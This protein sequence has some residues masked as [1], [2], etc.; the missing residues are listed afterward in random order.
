MYEAEDMIEGATPGDPVVRLLGMAFM[1]PV[2]GYVLVTPGHPASKGAGKVLRALCTVLVSAAILVV[3]T[4][5][6][7]HVSHT[8]INAQYSAFNS[9]KVEGELGIRI[10]L[11][12]ATVQLYGSVPELPL[13]KV[14]YNEKFTFSYAEDMKRHYH[15]VLERGLPYPVLTAAEYL[16][17]DNDG[18]RWGRFYRQ[19]GYYS[20]FCLWSAFAL[21]LLSNILWPVDVRYSSIC[22][23]I[24]GKLLLVTNVVYSANLPKRPLAIP[25]EGQM[26]EFSYGW[27][28]YLTFAVGVL[29]LTFGSTVLAL[30]HLRTTHQLGDASSSSEK[31]SH[32]GDEQ[33]EKSWR[34]QVN[35]YQKLYDKSAT[36]LCWTQ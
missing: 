1:A 20:Y 30:H 7:W 28:Y 19:A 16:S 11:G 24:T 31:F 23:M 15:E 9:R 13:T 27:C 5:S 36:D 10:G 25:C 26:L 22:L 32:A 34:R 17:V 35:K 14:N 2:A 8:W 33:Y 4:G 6:D 29:C 3:A 12:S 18:F 21:W